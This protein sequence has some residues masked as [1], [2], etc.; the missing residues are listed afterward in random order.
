M[1]CPVEFQLF[2]LLDG[3]LLPE[4][5]AAVAAH[6]AGCATCGLWVRSTRQLIEDI[7]APPVDE[8]PWEPER[9]IDDIMARIRREDAEAAPETGA[10]AKAAPALR[11]VPLESTD[12]GPTRSTVAAHPAPTD[13]AGPSSRSQRHARWWQRA[14]V[15]TS[16]AASFALGWSVGARQLVALSHDPRTTVVDGRQHP[17]HLAKT[18][19]GGH[20]YIAT[21][22]V[23]EKG[24]P[25][26]AQGPAVPV[27]DR[28]SVGAASLLFLMS[29]KP[30][31]LD[32]LAALGG[33]DLTVAALQGRFPGVL[34]RQVDLGAT[35]AP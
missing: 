20:G 5:E 11:A 7:K 18:K 1:S 19:P 17:V 13:T 15:G 4:E 12:S 8:S 14:A 27:L 30:I 10:S 34:V 22:L 35:P 9:R 33:N 21:I 24:A 32:S 29:A 2:M 25:H 3:G 6:V 23:D 16:I 28:N 26:L 31:D